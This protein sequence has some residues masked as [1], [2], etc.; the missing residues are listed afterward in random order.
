MM[1][2]FGS[3]FIDNSGALA[4]AASTNPPATAPLPGGSQSSLFIG[5][6]RHF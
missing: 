3:A 4:I 5:F 6:K 1:L 2:Y